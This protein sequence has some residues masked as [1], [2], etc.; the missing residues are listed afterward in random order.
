MEDKEILAQKR[1]RAV[2]ARKKISKDSR[3]KQG[4][5]KH[6]NFLIKNIVNDYL[7]DML[8][9]EAKGGEA[10][11]KQF[12]DEYM[13]Q[14]IKNPNSQAAAFFAD[15]IIAKDILS[16]LDAKHEKEMA[17]DLDFLRY[18]VLKQF[19]DKQREV[20][21]ELNHRDKIMCL[22][23][24]R[25]GKSTLAAGAIVTCAIDNDSSILYF[26][27]TFENGKK[28]IF[29]NVIKY[30]DSVNFGIMES[31]KTDGFIKFNNGST[32]Q[33]FGNANNQEAD[34]A[35]G[36]KARL[37][38]I[39]EIGHQR[40]LDYLINEVL[41]PLMADYK[42][43]TL[44]LLGTP[45]R[46][47]NHFSSKIW[48][49]DKTFKKY[50]WSL[51]ENPY[52]PNA[53]KVIDDICKAKGISIDTPFIQREYFG[54]IAPDTDA[55]IY[56]KRSYF[57]SLESEAVMITDIVIG[58]DYG[59][60]DFNAISVIAY[61]RHDKKS[62]MIEEEKFNRATVSDIIAVIKRHY[63]D[64][65]KT[66]E[67]FRVN[68]Q[69]HLTIWADTNEESITADLMIK[70]KMPAFNCYKYD[71]MYAV[72]MLKDELAT[73]RMKILKGGY[74][75]DE[76]NKIL[77][78]RD[79]DDNIINEID[80]TYFHADSLMSV[81]YASRKMF[82]DMDYDVSFKESRPKVSMFETDS[83]GTI[84]GYTTTETTSFED[85]GIVG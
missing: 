46:L 85:S 84:Q 51:L 81:L 43:S 22:T 4:E 1:E 31:R 14:A 49:N 26:N 29:D 23:S 18:R 34:K 62:F 82:F 39:D 55:L 80:D 41:T 19:Y 5:T 71:K 63:E 53:Q 11:Y 42:D 27:R 24:R 74:F 12:L 28:Q 61:N 45:S 77:Y 56:R 70:H 69:D 25:T 47:P 30:S 75:D 9:Q 2:N 57:E 20:I 60:S 83:K 72:E 16:V 73:G 78:A 3:K 35:R 6:Q 36:F 66:L 21:L 32:L 33:I 79:D 8:L 68:P 76:C 44:L 37:V 48:E 58:V 54:K 64:A 67:K 65:K 7:R 59:F 15:R 17:R 50:N 40:N 10:N 13:K 52:I 38:I